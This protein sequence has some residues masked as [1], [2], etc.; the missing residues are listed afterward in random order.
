M[1]P[2][3]VVACFRGIFIVFSLLQVGFWS[4]SELENALEL[5]SVMCV[6]ILFSARNAVQFVVFLCPPKRLFFIGFFFFLP[7]WPCF[8][9]RHCRPFL[10]ECFWNLIRLFVNT[11]FFFLFFFF[12]D[13][14]LLS[15]LFTHPLCLE[16]CSCH[17]TLLLLAL[18]SC[19]KFPARYQAFGLLRLCLSVFVLSASQMFCSVSFWSWRCVVASAFSFAFPCL[20]C[21]PS[22]GPTWV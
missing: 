18:R 13:F 17:S 2:S 19:L 21:F 9:I 14:A 3:W 5:L 10:G 11:F 12:S 1:H 20:T 6:L 4:W 22:W 7:A 16:K 8:F 15:A